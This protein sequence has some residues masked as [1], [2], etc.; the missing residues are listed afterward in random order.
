MRSVEPRDVPSLVEI[1][2]QAYSYQDA[3][4]GKSR[5]NAE[6]LAGRTAETDFYIVVV[7]GDIVGCVY[8]EPKEKVLHF[9]L[10]TV[11]P[12]YRGSGLAPAIIDA[13]EAYATSESYES[14]ELQY[15]S[16]APWLEAYYEKYGFSKTGESIEWG[17]I[18]LLT[19]RKS[20]LA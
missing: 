14:I 13:I 11:M 1:I 12:E 9:G 20:L 19:M 16:L 3:A 8:L 7:K 10:L 18:D 15:M 4:K 17:T 6:H 5:T 2:N